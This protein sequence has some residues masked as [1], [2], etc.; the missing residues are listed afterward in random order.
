[1]IQPSKLLP[2][3]S[4][5]VLALALHQGALAGD[6]AAPAAAP[7]A[8]AAAP[9]A[10]ASPREAM[11]QRRAAAM[12]EREA[13]YEEL[14][15]SAAEVGLELPEIPPWAQQPGIMPF[16]ADTGQGME[17]PEPMS[18]EE[19]EAM[20]MKRWEAMRE[21]AAENGYE[22]PETPPW[23]ARE[24]RMKAMQERMEQ[25]RETIETLTEEQKEAVKAVFG[26]PRGMRH[27]RMGHPG[28]R[29]G[30]GGPGYGPIGSP[31]G[32]QQGSMPAQPEPA[33]PTE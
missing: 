32:A 1:M 26:G 2:I 15:K 17:M 7:P 6:D 30:M 25:Y 33:T 24:E 13:R 27:G 11:E 14:R 20:R 5:A 4:A 9:P 8:P 3:G 31:M 16:P 12:A 29:S 19:W 23:K 10:A 22:M 28:C 18:R 21:R